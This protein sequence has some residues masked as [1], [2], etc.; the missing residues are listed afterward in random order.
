M[1]DLGKS[2]I[3]FCVEFPVHLVDNVDKE[4]VTVFAER[5]HKYQS[6]YENTNHPRY[7]MYSIFKSI[8]DFELSP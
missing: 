1:I 2:L 8:F 6:S 7:Q 4:S 5:S 3:F